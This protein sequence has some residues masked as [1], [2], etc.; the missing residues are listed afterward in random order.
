MNTAIGLLRQVYKP[1]FTYILLFCWSGT[2]AQ[3]NLVPNPSFEDTLAC[4]WSNSL[5]SDV[6]AFCTGNWYTATLLSPDYFHTCAN[7]SIVGIPLSTGFGYQHAYTGNAYA[8][9]TAISILDTFP[10]SEYIETQLTESLEA[11]ASYEV[12]FW[13]SLADQSGI[14]VGEMGAYFSEEKFFGNTDLLISETPQIKH[15]G[16]YLTDTSS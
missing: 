9:Y 13:V 3:V 5:G 8:G 1:F 4:P 16:G 14:G 12:S 15:T 7:G 10:Y 2:Y 6:L 11:C